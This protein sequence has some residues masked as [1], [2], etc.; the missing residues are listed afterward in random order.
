MVFDG[1]NKEKWN[2]AYN[3]TVA[4]GVF[5][6]RNTELGEAFE[7]DILNKFGAKLQGLD[8]AGDAEKATEIINQWARL[9][10]AFIS[11]AVKLNKRNDKWNGIAL[12]P[13]T[14]QRYNCNGTGILNL[15]QV[16]LARCL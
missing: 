16:K 11:S 9:I 8:F 12:V 6:H 1:I 13:R 14:T 4:N 5:Y 7:S 3:L 15:L 10:L 2:N